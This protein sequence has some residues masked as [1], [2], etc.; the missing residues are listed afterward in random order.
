MA[1][2]I[3]AI[4][5][6][7]FGT[8]V[9]S[10]DPE[11]AIIKAFKLKQDYKA[12]Q[13]AAMGKTPPTI[14]KA[15]LELI[16]KRLG[17]PSKKENFERLQKILEKELKIVK[18]FPDATKALRA[19]KAKGLKLGIVSNSWNPAVSKIKKESKI[20]EFFDCMVFSHKTG[21]FKPD[22]K[23]YSKCLDCL[24]VKPE[25]ALMVGDSLKNDI[26]A[27]SKIGLK[28]I[29][30]DGAKKRIDSKAP[31]AIISNLKELALE[32]KK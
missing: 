25:N 6:D 7:L 14:N 12:V 20:L 32:I 21:L 24:G 31:I 2:K 22:K 8:L 16:A 4:I 17:I 13:K 26:I 3:Q 23:I 27:P 19:L 10:G 5:F 29:L 28:G 18:P 1:Q 9:A 11:L 15:Y 30:L